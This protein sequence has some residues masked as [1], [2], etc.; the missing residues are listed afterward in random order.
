M[1]R[2]PLRDQRHTRSHDQAK[3]ATCRLKPTSTDD[4]KRWGSAAGATL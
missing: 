4:P 3:E 1:T 2:Q